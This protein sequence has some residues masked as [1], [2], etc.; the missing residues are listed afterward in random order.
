[1]AQR[2][3]TSCI[4]SSWSWEEGTQVE[5]L[6]S[7]MGT[8][9]LVVLE[10]VHGY[11]RLDPAKACTEGITLRQLV[12]WYTAFGAPTVQVSFNGKHLKNQ[13][14]CCFFLNAKHGSSFVDER[15]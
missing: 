7:E 14:V 6:T 3:E 2:L 1:M 12:A 11:M 13:I 10:D 8:H 15:N 5:E 4:L 9:V